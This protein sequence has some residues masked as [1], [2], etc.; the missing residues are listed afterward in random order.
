[1]Y[2]VQTP[3]TTVY[4][5]PS[6]R[7]DE[8]HQHALILVVYGLKKGVQQVRASYLLP[9]GAVHTCFG[10]VPVRAYVHLHTDFL[11]CLL[12]RTFASV[13]TYMVHTR[14]HSYFGGSLL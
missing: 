11:I 1:M 8:T 6:G 9:Y 5:C 2:T 10:Y 4:R 13:R 14:S 7:N 12:I 3:P